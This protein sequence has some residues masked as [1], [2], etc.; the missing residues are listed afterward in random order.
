MSQKLHVV[1]M[2]I[3]VIEGLDTYAP[4][5]PISEDPPL[6]GEE[7]L[8][9]LLAISQVVS[10]REEL[11]PRMAALELDIMFLEAGRYGP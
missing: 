4:P 1:P 10:G 8:S 2:E 3:D 9:V 6:V 5:R 7:D 11:L